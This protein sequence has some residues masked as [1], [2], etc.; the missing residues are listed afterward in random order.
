FVLAEI[1]GT[2]LENSATQSYM[3]P[4]GSLFYNPYWNGMHP[5]M[6]AYMHSYYMAAYC[7]GQFGVPGMKPPKTGPHRESSK[8]QESHKE[9][10]SSADVTSSKD[11]ESHRSRR[12][13]SSRAD[14]TSKKLK[15]ANLLL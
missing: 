12:E 4:G 11:Q 10:R 5:G 1:Q 3:T 13:V 14:V 2:T 6:T 8:D 7:H 9:L 15:R